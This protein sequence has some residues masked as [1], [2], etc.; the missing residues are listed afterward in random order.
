MQQTAPVMETSATVAHQRATV[1]DRVDGTIRRDTV[2]Q[3]HQGICNAIETGGNP[4]AGAG[5]VHAGGMEPPKG[6]V[7]TMGT[8]VRTVVFVTLT[9]MF[10]SLSFAAIEHSHTI[11]ARDTSVELV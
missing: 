7:A 1:G 4:F 3:G 2:L 5:L 11:S 8:F 6:I 9:T 10:A